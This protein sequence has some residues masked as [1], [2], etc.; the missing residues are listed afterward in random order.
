VNGDATER[1][2]GGLATRHG[3]DV[4]GDL[5]LFGDVVLVSDL[6]LVAVL[7]LIRLSSEESVRASEE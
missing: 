7:A 6:V 5:V 1:T 3:E 4:D 2:D